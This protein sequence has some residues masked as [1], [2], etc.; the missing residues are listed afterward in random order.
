MDLALTEGKS[1]THVE[2]IRI[3]LTYANSY[4]N[5]PYEPEKYNFVQYAV[6]KGY[7]VFFYDRLGVGSSTKYVK[8]DI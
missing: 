3:E 6:S 2:N 5:S 8:P 7:S 1:P 4:W